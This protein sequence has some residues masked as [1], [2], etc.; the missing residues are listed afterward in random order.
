MVI[1]VCSVFSGPTVASSLRHILG[2]AWDGPQHRFSNLLFGADVWSV[3]CSSIRSGI[4]R[5]DTVYPRRSSLPVRWMS[6]GIPKS[7]NDSIAEKIYD[8]HRA[9]YAGHL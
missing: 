9:E 1:S 7:V 6:D 5:A 2:C 4:A 8:A 3:Q